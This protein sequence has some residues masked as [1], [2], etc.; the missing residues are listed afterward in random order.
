MATTKQHK[1]PMEDEARQKVPIIPALAAVLNESEEVT[2]LRAPSPIFRRDGKALNKKR[3][4]ESN[5][6]ARRLA[7]QICI[8]RSAS[9]YRDA[10]GFSRHSGGA[11]E[12][13]C[14]LQ[15]RLCQSALHQLSW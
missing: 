15:P 5:R 2:N 6:A 11:P 1:A 14:G 7:R 13:R 9:L 3:F 10:P 12:H 4:Q 8:S